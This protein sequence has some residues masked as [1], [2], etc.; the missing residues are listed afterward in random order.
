MQS[1]ID[2]LLVLVLVL[3]CRIQWECGAQHSYKK[4]KVH[5]ITKVRGAIMNTITINDY[6]YVEQS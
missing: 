5:V 1:K 2:I 6:N 4:C 3:V